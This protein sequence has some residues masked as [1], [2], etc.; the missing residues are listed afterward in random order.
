M[1]VKNLNYSEGNKLIKDFNFKQIHYNPND[2]EHI[3]YISTDK[4][5]LIYFNLHFIKF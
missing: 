2:K 3:Y 5:F 1:D 4:R